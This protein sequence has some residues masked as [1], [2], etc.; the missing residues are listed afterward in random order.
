MQAVLS[1]LCAAALLFTT[2]GSYLSPLPALLNRKH[3]DA[4]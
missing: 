1:F 4:G 3:R 2:L